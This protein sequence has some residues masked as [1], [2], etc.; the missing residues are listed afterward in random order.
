MYESICSIIIYLFYIYLRLLYQVCTQEMSEA[1]PYHADII[2]SI[3]S[4][5]DHEYLEWRHN[6]R[7]INNG[8]PKITALVDG[9]FSQSIT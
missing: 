7:D 8:K 2:N 3:D 5:I 4:T 1:C 9:I 6:Q